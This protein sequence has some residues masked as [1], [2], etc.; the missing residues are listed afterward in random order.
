[1]ISQLELPTRPL[2]RRTDPDTSHAAARAMKDSDKVCARVLAVIKSFG[3]RGCVSDEVLHDEALFDLEYGTIT[4]RYR[5][6]LNKGLIVDTG[7]RRPG[8]SG[9]PQRVMR[10]IV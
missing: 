4:P 2:A 8:I 10:A 6:L 9:R 5:Q 3:E 7:E 1:M